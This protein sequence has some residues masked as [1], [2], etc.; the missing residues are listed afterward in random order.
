M[1]IVIDITDAYSGQP[2]RQH[3]P[4]AR[5]IHRF[6]PTQAILETQRPQAWGLTDDGGQ[7]ATSHGPIGIR[8]FKVDGRDAAAAQLRS[9]GWTDLARMDA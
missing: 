4:T 3:D 2:V 6:G 7:S 8:V 1:L 5:M 9:W